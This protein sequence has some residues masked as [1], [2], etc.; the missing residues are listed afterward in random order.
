M[1]VACELR[2]AAV[3]VDQALGEF[4]G[5]GGGIANTLYPWDF[6]D[7]FQ[8]QR[9]IRAFGPTT[10]ALAAYVSAVGI[11]VLAQQRDFLHACQRQLRHFAEHIVERS[12]DFLAARERNDAEAA[13]LAAAFHDGDEGGYALDPRR[14]QAVELLDFGK[15]NV[16]L[17][18]ARALS[19][20]DQGGQAVQRLRTE[21]HVD[22]W[23]AR[24]DGGALLAGDAAAYAYDHLGTR[25]LQVLHPSQ[26]V[27]HFLLRFLAHRTGVE[28]DDIGFAGIG[29]GF[30]AFGRGKHVG[31]LGRVVFVHLATERFDVELARHAH[32]GG[33]SGAAAS[34]GVSTHTR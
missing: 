6:R 3:G 30:H 8:E 15:G 23:C 22:V 16:D 17:R 20:R 19:R 29:G 4:L 2:R 11:D 13:V 10:F 24:H 33:L 1:H 26:V 34:F 21:H 7:V 5:M 31:H 18:P 28:Y 32:R 9:E 25:P 14:R 27:K 12:R